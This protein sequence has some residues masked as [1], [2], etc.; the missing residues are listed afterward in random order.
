MIENEEVIVDLLIVIDLVNLFHFVFHVISGF[1]VALCFIG[2]TA[3][4]ESTEPIY[5]IFVSII[6]IVVI[7]GRKN[8]RHILQSSGEDVGP[9]S[10]DQSE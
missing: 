3:T 10:H 5:L 9:V 4:V 6:V 1:S 8:N 2:S 7:F